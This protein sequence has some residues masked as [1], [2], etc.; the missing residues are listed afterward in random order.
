MSYHFVNFNK[1]LACFFPNHVS[2]DFENHNHPTLF[3][4][5]TK[6]YVNLKIDLPAIQSDFED[7]KDLL[8]ELNPKFEKK[9]NE[10]SNSLNEVN[11]ESDKE[12]LVKP[13]NKFGRFLGT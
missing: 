1:N 10:I 2:K 8:I 9:L 13:F 7:F 5:E 12:N 6:I 4:V 3:N 11:V